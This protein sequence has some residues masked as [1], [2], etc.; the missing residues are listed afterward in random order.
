[1]FE[2]FTERARKV[3]VKAQDEARFLKQ[4][5][6]GTEHI[7]L[8]LIKEV[9]RISSNEMVPTGQN[10]SNSHLLNTVLMFLDS[11]SQYLATTPLLVH[12]GTMMLRLMA[13]QFISTSEIRIRTLGHTWP[14]AQQV[15][16]LG[17]MNLAS[18]FR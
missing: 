8:G 14:S 5:Y 3:V 16:A 18:R 11:L 15:M 12:L 13:V 1:M 17:T 7:L 4:N 6:I 10:K 2:R 9:L